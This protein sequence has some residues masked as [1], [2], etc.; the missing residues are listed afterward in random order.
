MSLR[1]T[2]GMQLMASLAGSKFAE[3]LHELCLD[4]QFNSMVLKRVGASGRVVIGQLLYKA[5]MA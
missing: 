3:T 5:C 4:L 2:R 1:C